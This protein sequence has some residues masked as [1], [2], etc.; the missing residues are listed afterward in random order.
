MSIVL[1]CAVVLAALVLPVPIG[2][3]RQRSHS[4]PATQYN[5]TLSA[6]AVVVVVV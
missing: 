5:T 2:L 3:I 4:V 6:A 1:S